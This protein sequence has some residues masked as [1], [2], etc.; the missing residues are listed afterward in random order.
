MTEL[1]ITLQI[2]WFNLFSSAI[3]RISSIQKT[4]WIR[5]IP[6]KGLSTLQAWLSTSLPQ[7]SGPCVTL[8]SMGI[9]CG[10]CWCWRLQVFSVYSR[11]KLLKPSRALLL[12]LISL[13]VFSWYIVVQLFL[14]CVVIVSGKESSSF[15]V[16]VHVCPPPG[17]FKPNRFHPQRNNVRTD[18][19]TGL[20]TPL[21]GRIQN[22]FSKVVYKS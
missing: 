12:Y 1:V 21:S 2:H 3:V 20:Q 7:T 8:V 6:G 4:C 5:G 18:W 15:S 11:F 13:A 10:L 14:G 9:D 19:Y 17:F 16:R 22:L